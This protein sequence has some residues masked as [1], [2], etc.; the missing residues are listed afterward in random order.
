MVKL[1]TTK[2]VS[3]LSTIQRMLDD[4]EEY[5]RAVQDLRRKLKRHKPGSEGYHDLLPE[6]C[7]QVD[8]LRLKAQH[9]VQALEEYEDSLSD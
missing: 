5:V 4:V 2:A 7:V 8:V 3:T 9:A 1:M 6:L